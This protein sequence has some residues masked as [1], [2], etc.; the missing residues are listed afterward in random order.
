MSPIGV[1]F[2]FASATVV[3]AAQLPSPASNTASANP[4]SAQAQLAPLIALPQPTP[5][6]LSPWDEFA[7]RPF[8]LEARY[9][10]GSPVG[11]IGVAAE[12]SPVPALALGCGAGTNLVGLQL[13]C[14]LSGR[15]VLRSREH[16]LGVEWAR[17]ITLSSGFSEGSY[18]Q[19][20]NVFENLPI[21]GPGTASRNYSRAYWWNTDIG[22]E[23]KNATRRRV[24]GPDRR[25][26]RG[27]GRRLAGRV[28]DRLDSASSAA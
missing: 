10:L 4:A 26:P 25:L 2:A 24:Q 19:R 5:L 9:G 6:Q 28:C 8:T 23:E 21:D 1:F 14:W 18:V 12:L 11:F 7:A 22:F 16:A 13:A 3:P 20:A 27:D 15:V 17:A